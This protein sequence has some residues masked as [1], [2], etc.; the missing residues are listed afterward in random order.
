MP[1]TSNGKPNDP[2]RPSSYDDIVRKT[3][4]DPD[5][6]ARPTRGQEQLAREGYR[7]LD[8]DERQLTDRVLHALATSGQDVSGVAVE[9]SRDLVTLHGR[10]NDPSVLRN[11][12]DIVAAVPGVA[13]IHNQLVIGAS[14]R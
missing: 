14:P 1:R 2:N 6:S 11:V 8:D 5:S 9:V 10:V 3:V 7:A 4:V 12:E 13:T